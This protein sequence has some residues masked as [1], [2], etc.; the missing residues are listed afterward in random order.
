M[1]AFTLRQLLHRDRKR[2]V[3]AALL[4]AAES[5]SPSPA[6]DIDAGETDESPL[7]FELMRSS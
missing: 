4:S 1:I 6:A 2:A 5:M 3:S 7:V